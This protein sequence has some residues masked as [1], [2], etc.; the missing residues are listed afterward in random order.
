MIVRLLAAAH[1]PA[2]SA[3]HVLG[4]AMLE[5]NDVL[6]FLAIARQRSL[7][8]AA[9]ELKVTQPTMGRRLELLEERIGVRLFERSATG[10]VLTEFGA[11]LVPAAERM[12]EAALA[13]ERHLAGRGTG[14]DGS[15]RVTCVEWFGSHVLAPIIAAFSHLHP[16]ITVQLIADG[17]TLNLGRHE[18]DIALRFAEFGQNGVVQRKATEIG[19]GLYASETYLRAHGEP[20]FA[21]GCEGHALITVDE[22]LG[23]LADVHWLRQ[24]ASKARI[25]FRSNSRDTQVHTA[26]AGTGL[27]SL[28]RC[29]GDG[30]AG[31]RRLHPPVPAPIREVWLGYHQDLRETPRIRAVAGFIA[32]ELRRQ[33]PVLNPAD[34]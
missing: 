8:A 21:T 32:E 10:A 28:P 23:H 33:G 2:A 7:S 14:L 18:A 6:V 19:Y 25:A 9:R 11:S 15:V 4:E 26:L 34:S 16:G 24:I 29:M 30:V 17:R 27:V 22:A 1:A 20:D 3:L 13:F 12:E 31:L 5:W